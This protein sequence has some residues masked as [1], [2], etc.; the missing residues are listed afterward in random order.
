MN[1]KEP[2][3]MYICY[4]RFG[5]STCIATALVSSN[6]SLMKQSSYKYLDSFCKEYSV[7]SNWIACM[8]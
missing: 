8:E 5:T 2:L 7:G 1:I 4:E 3:H 6:R